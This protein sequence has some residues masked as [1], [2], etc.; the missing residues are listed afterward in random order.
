[1]N[2]PKKKHYSPRSTKKWSQEKRGT[3]ALCGQRDMQTR[4]DGGPDC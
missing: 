1:M 2:L 3:T 4:V